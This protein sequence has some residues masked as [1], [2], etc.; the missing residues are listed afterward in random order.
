MV[1]IMNSTIDSLMSKVEKKCEAGEEF[2]IYPMYGGLTI[3]IIARTAFGIQ[4]DSQNNPND[5]LLRTNKIL[6]SEDITS[7]V[8]VL[9]SEAAVIGFPDGW[10]LGT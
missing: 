1:P 3:D 8:Y 5:L 9:A 4:T 6:F 7:P 10:A 2:D